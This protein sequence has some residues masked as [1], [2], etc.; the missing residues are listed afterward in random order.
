MDTYKTINNTSEGLYKEKGSKFISYAYHVETVEEVSEIV[1]R[2][3]KEYFDAR[4]HCFAW[5]MGA[6]G[7]KTRVVDDGEPSSTAGKP[8]LGQILSLEVTD[9]LIVVIRYF[10]GTLL[11]ASGLIRAYKEAAYDALTNAEIVEKF[12]ET[13]FDIKFT[14][15]VMNDVMKIIK[16]T[17]PNVL[18]KV[19]DIDCFMKL[20]IRESLADGLLER[21]KKVEGIEIEIDN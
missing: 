5:R 9:V 6:K 11:G 15:F 21:L 4:H 10:G 20:S 8:I 12:V 13:T 7:E 14:Y 18:E 1:S 16:D 3:K 2:L 19:F 17:N